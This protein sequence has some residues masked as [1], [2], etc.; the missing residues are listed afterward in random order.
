LEDHILN[1]LLKAE[2]YWKKAAIADKITKIDMAKELNNLKMFSLNQLAKIVRIPARE[3]SSRMSP[4]SGGG[5]FEPETLSALAVVR[6]KKLAGEAIPQALLQLIVESDTSYSCACE[7]TGIPYST[8]YKLV[9]PKD[10][11]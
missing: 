9:A 10:R 7:L 3:L 8:Y 6:R 2:S 4:K 5:R 11:K 1:G